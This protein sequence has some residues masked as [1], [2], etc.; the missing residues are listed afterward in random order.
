METAHRL[1]TQDADEQV[2][3]RVDMAIDEVL[4]FQQ[5]FYA[6]VKDTA[7]GPGSFS[8]GGSGDE[9]K[10]CSG[11]GGV[12]ATGGGDVGGARRA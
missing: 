2:R 4:E 3:R 5:N 1:V 7:T 8:S 9:G 10:S 12:V 6:I 11:L